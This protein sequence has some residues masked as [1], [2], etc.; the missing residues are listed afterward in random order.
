MKDLITK[1]SAYYSRL[2]Q[3]ER[4]FIALAIIGIFAV[5]NLWLVFPNFGQLT[6]IE[7]RSRDA[8]GSSDTK[9]LPSWFPVFLQIYRVLAYVRTTCGNGWFETPA[10]QPTLYHSISGSSSP[11]LYSVVS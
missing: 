8:L 9:S 5:L 6:V 7:R 10:T 3:V 4:W 2:T 11:C 1:F